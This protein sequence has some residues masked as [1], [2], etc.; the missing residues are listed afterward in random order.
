MKKSLLVL[1]LIS[2]AALVFSQSTG[3]GVFKSLNLPASARI[4]ALGGNLIAIADGDL[5]LAFFNP[6]LLDS[7]MDKRL[8]MSYLNYFSDINLGSAHFAK[9]FSNIGTA[10]LSL[11]YLDYGDFTETDASNNNLGD[12]Q[13][14]DVIVNLGFGRQLDSNFTAGVNLKYINS[15]LAD[16]SSSGIAADFGLHYY[17]KKSLFS[18]ALL[19]KNIGTQLGNYTKGNKEKLPF[20]IQ[21]GFTKKLRHAPFRFG[22]MLENLQEWDIRRESEK[23]I[24]TIDPITEEIIEDNSFVAGDIFMRHLIFNTEVLISKNIIF[25]LGYNYR[26]RQELAFE[27]KSGTVGLSI[28]AS[29]KVSKFNI[30]YGRSTYHLAGPSN[31][32]TVNTSISDW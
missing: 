16:Y 6:A 28:G 24:V 3:N 20:E 9:H 25:R 29:V 18:A 21:A 7:T 10:S 23:N 27:E 8:E 31:H 19:L 22:F 4:G 32:F 5:G 17:K 26:R 1:L 11:Q 14:S 30:S 12:F 15:T 13:V 2:T